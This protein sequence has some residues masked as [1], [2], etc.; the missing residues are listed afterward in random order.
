MSLIEVSGVSFC[1]K[2]RT[3]LSDVNLKI[4]EGSFVAI[5][6]QS[7]AGK[8]TLARLLNATLVPQSGC[9]SVCGIAGN[10]R[11][12]KLS[13]R[14]NVALVMQNPESQIIGDTVEDDVAFALENMGLDRDEMEKRISDALKRTGLEKLRHRNP[15]ELSGGQKQLLAIAGSLATRCKCIVMDEAMSML[16]RRS[17]TGILGLIHDLNR[18]NGISIVLM[19]H[20]LD[21]AKEAD[22]VH[23]LE[24]GQI[25]ESGKSD[26]V[27]SRRP[28]SFASSLIKELNNRGANIATE[29][30][31]MTLLGR[32][33]NGGA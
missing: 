18:Q 31:L 19:T 15:R 10:D 27:L 17:R 28:S 9:I 14:S 26:E 30:E 1:Y 23:I 29:G 2:G 24:N 33:E 3:V 20:S 32:K 25:A 5:L 8:T 7:G 16:D 11:E 22:V 21:E 6:G 4:E 13:I 12:S